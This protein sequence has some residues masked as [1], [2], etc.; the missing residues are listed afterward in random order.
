MGSSSPSRRGGFRGTTCHGS[1]GCGTLCVHTCAIAYDERQ[2]EYVGIEPQQ[3]QQLENLTNDRLHT[4]GSKSLYPTFVNVG[5]KP[6]IEGHVDLF[7]VR[8]KA[9]QRI[10]QLPEVKDFI[11]VDKNLNVKK[12]D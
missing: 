11:L 2:L 1:G 5:E 4:N 12:I 8:F 6:S 3:M 9:K 10:S 7:V